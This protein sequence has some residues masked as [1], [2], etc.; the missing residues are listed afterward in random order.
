LIVAMIGATALGRRR[1]PAPPTRERR[2]GVV[3]GSLDEGREAIGA[4]P[5]G[6]S[7][8]SDRGEEEQP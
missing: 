3:S 7:A 8:E 1:V 2:E 4:V 5:V 6:G